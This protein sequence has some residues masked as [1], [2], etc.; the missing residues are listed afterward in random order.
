M[1]VMPIPVLGKL[2]HVGMNHIGD[3]RPMRG[4]IPMLDGNSLF[5]DR[6][7]AAR[8]EDWDSFCASFSF[9]FWIT[10]Y[11]PLF[12]FGRKMHNVVNR[13]KRRM[14]IR[15]FLMQEPAHDFRDAK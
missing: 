2:C 8:P 4:N 14:T 9:V 11:D 12:F 15:A 7:D 13:H 1:S 5:R 6:E 10:R 3:A